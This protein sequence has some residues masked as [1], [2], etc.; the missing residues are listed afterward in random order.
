MV[1][2]EHA[3]P[4]VL[5]CSPQCA[6]LFSNI[7]MIMKMKR[8]LPFSVIIYPASTKLNA[9]G[10][11]QSTKFI[12]QITSSHPDAFYTPNVKMTSPHWKFDLLSLIIVS[13]WQVGR[14]ECHGLYAG[15]TIHLSVCAGWENS[16]CQCEWK[17]WLGEWKTGLGKLNFA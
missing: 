2:R 8:L 13:S 6:P 14:C 15:F 11:Y 10:V 4:A 9:P 12:F 7:L 3:D 5:A 17:I 1:S 16:A